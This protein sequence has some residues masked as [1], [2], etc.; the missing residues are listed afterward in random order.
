MGNNNLGYMWALGE[1][2]VYT[3][4]L[5]DQKIPMVRGPFVAP[6]MGIML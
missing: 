1:D 4:A 6:Y 2:G 5:Q 3:I